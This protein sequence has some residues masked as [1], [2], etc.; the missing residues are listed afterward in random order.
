MRPCPNWTKPGDP[1]CGVWKMDLLRWLGQRFDLDTLIETGTSEGSCIVALQHDFK[2]IYSCELSPHYYQKSVVRCKS[3]SHA[4]IYQ[5][6][7]RDFLEGLLPKLYGKPVLFWLD[8]HVSAP[9]S[10][11][12][13]D[14]LPRELELI[15][16]FSPNSVVV[17]D[18]MLSDKLPQVI[19]QG[20]DLIHWEKVYFTGEIIMHPHLYA[21]VPELVTA[22]AMSARGF[23]GQ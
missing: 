11:D 15:N 16:Q 2:K 8:A 6:D 17:I 3:I 18:D 7:S 19:E 20:V 1:V 9:D 14:P 5:A 22:A 23:T 21:S 13:G 12:A 10:A 4:L